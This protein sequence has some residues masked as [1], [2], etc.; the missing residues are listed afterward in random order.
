MAQALHVISDSRKE[1]GS[2]EAWQG[3]KIFPHAARDFAFAFFGSLVDFFRI[4]IH[5]T[6]SFQDH[7]LSMSSRSFSS[8][9]EASSKIPRRRLW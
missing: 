3:T 1:S 8:M 4:Q 2:V 6:Y 7:I 5:W 9:A